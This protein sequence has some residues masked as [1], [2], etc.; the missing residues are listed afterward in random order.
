MADYLYIFIEKDEQADITLYLGDPKEEPDYPTLREYIEDN[1]YDADSSDSL[2]E[3]AY[4]NGDGDELEIEE[5]KTKGTDPEKVI[6]KLDQQLDEDSGEARNWMDW[7][8]ELR[9]SP[10]ARMRTFLCEDLDEDIPGVKLIEGDRPGS[11]MCYSTADDMETVLRLREILSDK[12]YEVEI[13]Y[14]S[15]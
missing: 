7:D 6:G 13:K 14:F 15:W 2:W 10:A 9:E 3:Y 8:F 12:G 5:H 4:E 1:G 11:N